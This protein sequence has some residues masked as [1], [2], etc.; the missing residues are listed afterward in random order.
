MEKTLRTMA[1]CLTMLLCSAVWIV[2]LWL[3]VRCANNPRELTIAAKLLLGG[4]GTGLIYFS[5][6]LLAQI[7]DL[8]SRH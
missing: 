3:A 5:Y 6:K 8:L 4:G 1:V 7:L 2:A